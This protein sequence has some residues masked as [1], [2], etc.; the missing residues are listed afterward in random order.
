MADFPSMKASQLLAVLCRSPL[1]YVVERRKGSHRRLVA[2]G[3]PP[4]TFAYHDG[5]TVPPGAV[6]KILMKDIGLSHDE[7]LELVR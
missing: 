7:A 4:L 3:R 2:E 1:N 6:R 5:A